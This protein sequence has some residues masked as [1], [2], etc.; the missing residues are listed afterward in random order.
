MLDGSRAARNE[1]ILFI[2]GDLVGLREDLIETMT[3]PLVSGQADFVKS[4][5]SRMKASAARPLVYS[6]FPKSLISN[7]IWMASSQYDDHC[8][9]PCHLIPIMAWISVY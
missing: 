2:D 5:Q 3:E 9:I 8:S 1:I 4:K 7:S 6:L